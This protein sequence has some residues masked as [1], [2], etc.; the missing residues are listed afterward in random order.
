MERIEDILDL[1]LEELKN[2][3]TVQEVLAKHP[4]HAE[5]LKP[6]LSTAAK[7]QSMPKPQP[8]TNAVYNALVEA[9]KYLPAEKVSKT[10]LS[11]DWFLNPRF[12]FARA[13]AII[14]I[15]SLLSWSTVT[16]SASALP[17]DFLYPVKVITEKVKIILTVNPEGEAELRLTFSEERMKELL[18][19][20]SKNGV[21]DNRLIGAMLDEANSALNKISSLPREKQPLFYSKVNHFNSYQKETLQSI[22]PHVSGQQ[23]EFI[24]K[25]IEI[26]SGRG[27]WMQK[28][29]SRGMYCP[30]DD[31]AGCDWK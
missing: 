6:L 27:E 10:R 13:I 17:G 2:G 9:G 18:S 19:L 15:L 26:C 21:I 5:E 16:A 14:L 22:Q 20:Y 7:I 30:W 23:K 12:V 4:S 3:K 31:S 8:S 29:M 11:F 1:C 24:D 25:A 28:M